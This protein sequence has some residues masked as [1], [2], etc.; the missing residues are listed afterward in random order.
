MTPY[1][2]LTPHDVVEATE[3]DLDD[4]DASKD[5]LCWGRLKGGRRCWNRTR[6]MSGD[7]T[8]STIEQDRRPM[9]PTCKTHTKQQITAGI[10]QA[11]LLCGGNCNAKFR[12]EPH[13]FSSCSMH[14][15]TA[16]VMPCYLLKIPTELRCR[17]FSFLLPDQSVPARFSS[18]SMLRSDSE[19]C[20]PQIL[21]VNHQIYEESAVVLY[22][23]NTFEIEISGGATITM[24][25]S[26]FDVQ[27]FPTTNQDRQ[28]SISPV[29]PGHAVE[30][31][32]ALYDY[33]MQLMLL[34]HQNK[35]RLL[36]VRQEQ[37]NVNSSPRS[38]IDDITSLSSDPKLHLHTSIWHPGGLSPANI[39]MIRSFQV[40]II[41]PYVPQPGLS[42]QQQIEFQRQQTLQQ[43]MALQ[44]QQAYMAAHQAAQQQALFHRQVQHI[45][46]GNMHP[47]IMPSVSLPAPSAGL[48]SVTQASPP[49]PSS[50]TAYNQA[51]P[52]VLPKSS[53]HGPPPPA[54]QRPPIFM[55][56]GSQP[57]GNVPP[58]HGLP[59]APNNTF[60]LPPTGP[61][62][63]P[64]R[65][66]GSN[67]ILEK[68][69]YETCDALNQI[70]ER[71]HL[72]PLP[73]LRLNVAIHIDQYEKQ[74][75][76]IAA[77]HLFL[78]TFRRLRN[79]VRPNVDRTIWV[80][81]FWHH[82]EIL[83]NVQDSSVCPTTKSKFI[84]QWKAEIS[85]QGRVPDPSPAVYTYWALHHICFDL[86][87]HQDAAPVPGPI[88]ISIRFYCEQKW[89]EK[90]RIWA[91]SDKLGRRYALFGKGIF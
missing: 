46:P 68:L 17:I 45:L 30:G 3:E 22:A 76:D 51:P 21:R 64:Q 73:I 83:H 52:V 23:Q 28:F 57:M 41:F 48:D 18:S 47:Q 55:T 74:E 8:T 32:H 12:W 36:M 53:L 31:N 42:F 14:A 81:Q 75:P 19:P 40:N 82:K 44:Q 29:V 91:L 33:Q 72:I 15:K 67:M 70:I 85:Q 86:Q 20:Y 7:S 60:P 66:P 62:M 77:A 87:A 58:Q 50:S 61:L 5:N 59:G 69:K 26:R 9:L 54:Y 13:G 65:M 71:L 34:E 56:H 80:N 79:V 35:K 6:A 2:L 63:P 84:S 39:D 11:R 78:N 38:R 1:P 49:P 43:R 10:C 89:R 90:R 27:S 25:N 4:D 24:C 16:G 88:L 37:D